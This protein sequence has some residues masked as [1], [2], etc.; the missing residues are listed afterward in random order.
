MSLAL[1]RSSVLT[2]KQQNSALLCPSP[3]DCMRVRVGL[4]LQPHTCT[5]K[6]PAPKER[7]GR[8]HLPLGQKAQ[9]GANQRHLG[10]G[11]SSI[12]GQPF[13]FVTGSELGPLSSECSLTESHGC[14]I[15]NVLTFALAS[16]FCNTLHATQVQYALPHRIVL[17]YPH[18][19][20]IG[21]PMHTQ[22]V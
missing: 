16:G 7:N 6:R 21:R 9:E 3:F 1:A 15:C 14:R 11:G 19:V 20:C 17:V 10:I 8:G 12:F 18:N 2:S 4:A 22:Q 5:H 13:V